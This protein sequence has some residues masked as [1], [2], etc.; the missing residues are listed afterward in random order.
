MDLAADVLLGLM[1]QV[2]VVSPLHGSLQ[3]Q[4][5]QQAY[6]DGEQVQQK[7]ADA[8]NRLVRRMNIKHGSR[9]AGR[10]AR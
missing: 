1:S 10:D 9:V 4:R 5:N 2:H 8:V 7:V 6:R 3:A